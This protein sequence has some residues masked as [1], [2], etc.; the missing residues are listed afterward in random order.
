M[1]TYTNTYTCITC[2]LHIHI[3]QIH[4]FLCVCVCDVSIY[5]HHDRWWTIIPGLRKQ[6]N[7]KGVRLSAEHLFTCPGSAPPHQ[8]RRWDVSDR[9]SDPRG[10]A[11]SDPVDSGHEGR[12]EACFCSGRGLWWSS[13]LE[14][15][16]S[17]RWWP[18]GLWT[19]LQTQELDI[20]W[21]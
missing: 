11:P 8:P 21:L 2:V 18:W 6:K 12:Q 13:N 1:C 20:L 16:C 15:F 5:T 19:L 7:Q 3:T 9:N 4:V 10:L 17:S 14:N